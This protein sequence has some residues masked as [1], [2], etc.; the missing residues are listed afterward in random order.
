MDARRS[1]W[2]GVVAL[3]L[4]VLVGCG[5]EDADPGSGDGSGGA[6][7]SG[8]ASGSEGPDD[9]GSEGSDGSGDG[10]D[11]GAAGGSDGGTGPD[12]G[13]E[14]EASTGE[15]LPELEGEEC[16]AEVEITGAL[17]ASWSGDAV[18]ASGGASGAP[19]LYQAVSEDGVSVTVNAGGP[20]F[21]A[22]VLVADAGGMTYGSTPGA[23]GVDASAD[24]TGATVDTELL[25][26]ELPGEAARVVATFSC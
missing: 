14:G 7:E 5:G 18:T 16:D 25:A 19:A 1:T 8:D 2:L 10:S 21:D 23:D 13:V 6:A 26:P 12:E 11:E 24:G 3:S 15:P 9:G 4:T 20:G 22:A 17:E